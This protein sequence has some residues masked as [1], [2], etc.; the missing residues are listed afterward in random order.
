MKHKWQIVVGLLMVIMLAACSSSNGETEKGKE[1]LTL[2]FWGA[3]P[4]YQA[5]MNKVLVDK[6]NQSQDKYELVVEFRNSVDKDISVALSAGQGPD[7]VYGSGPSFVIPYAEAGKIEPLDTYAEK[8]GWKDRIIDSVYESGTVNGKLYSLGNS[9]NTEGIFYNKKVLKDN[10]WEVPK[11]VED[12]EKIMDEAMKKGM[13]GSVTG[14]KGWKPVNENYT[15]IFL[16][17]F[18]GRNTVYE[19][20]TG[21]KK[22]TDPAIVGALDKSKEWYKKGYLAGNDY[23]NLTFNEA[24]QLLADEKSPFFF[25][26]S[27]VFQFAAQSFTD[28]IVDNLGFMPFPTMG[29]S[30]D[31]PDYTLGVTASLSINANSKHKEGAAEVLDMMM[32]NAFMNEMTISWP[33]YWGVPLK[34]L[35]IETDKMS[36]LSKLYAES[37][38]DMIDGVN[39]G[40]FGYYAGVF[41][42]PAAKQVFL[43]IDSV[44]QDQTTSQALMEKAQTEFDKDVQ[45]GLLPPI[46]KP[47]K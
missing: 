3:A 15:S 24:I 26:P 14:N 7:I 46:P 35:K 36:A 45:K 6:Y 20:L 21:S 31:E 13:Y 23:T 42:P 40:H 30:P 1:K 18:A 12:I 27:L 8:Y 34:D 10:N 47:A 2:W 41:L 16:T 37:I 25:G 5:T 43:D 11:T 29:G 39:K 17:H 28:D 44:W 38:Y 22:W 33:G 32:T 9:L 4:E 19:A